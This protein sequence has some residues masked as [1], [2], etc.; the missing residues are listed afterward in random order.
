MQTPIFSPDSE[1]RLEQ[2]INRL[3]ERGFRLTPQRVAVLKI[4]ALSDGHPSVDQIY[5]QVHQ[6][7]PTTSRATIYKTVALLRELGEV[8]ELGFPDGSNRY[9]GNK[10]FPHPHVICTMCRTVQDP[11][12]AGVTDLTREVS[13]KTGFRISTHRLDFFGLCRA[14]QEAE[15]AKRPKDAAATETKPGL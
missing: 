13:T 15:H 10:P 9:D 14:C 3:K 11:N 2:M 6:D 7:F 8:L 12:L 4:L 1:A 5:E